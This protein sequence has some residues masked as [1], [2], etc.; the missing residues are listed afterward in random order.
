MVEERLD[1]IEAK[2]K[3]LEEKINLLTNKDY[4]R[5]ITN[6]SVRLLSREYGRLFKKLRDAFDQYDPKKQFNLRKILLSKL[7]EKE[8]NLDLY[9][10]VIKKF[11][12]NNNF[13]YNL[14]EYEILLH[15]LKIVKDNKVS[16][17]RLNLQLLD[18]I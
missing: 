14:S 6:E 11:L 16:K 15:K 7:P 1:A 3:Q 13:Q 18:L 9:L 2:L 8:T 10:S 5:N 12:E 17:K 4:F